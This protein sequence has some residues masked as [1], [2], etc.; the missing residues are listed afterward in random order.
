[1]NSVECGLD[2]GPDISAISLVFGVLYYQSLDTSSKEVQSN[3]VSP[4]VAVVKK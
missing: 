2:C 4:T 3:L 1:M